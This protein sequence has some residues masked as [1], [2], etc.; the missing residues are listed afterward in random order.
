MDFVLGLPKTQRG[1]DSIYVVVDRFSKMAHFIACKKTNDATQI[2]NLFFSE[3][4]RLHGLPVS[5]VSD[6]DTKFVGHFW[7]TL[8]KKLGTKLSFSSAYHPQT[9]GQTEV[10]NR[11]L[12]NILRTLVHQNPKQWDL[13]LAQAEFAYNDTPNRSTGMSPFQIV[14]GMHPRGVY[15]LRDLG[16]QEARSASAEDFAEQMQKLHEEVKDKL[17]ESSRRYKQ[18]ADLKRREKEFQVG[19]LV[20]AY[21]RKERFPTRT[22][23]KLKLKKTGPCK[24]KRKISANAYEIEL[25]EGIE[26]SPIFNIADLYPFRE[27][28]TELQKEVT[29]DEIQTVDWEEQVPKSSQKEVEAILDRRISKKTRGKTYFQYL[30][31]WKEQPVEDSSWL[32]TIELQKYGVSP[33]GLKYK[34]FLPRESDA[35]ASALAS[36]VEDCPHVVANH[37]KFIDCYRE[38]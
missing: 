32:T 35:G 38:E 28:E 33:E 37:S 31:K 7:R 2:A 6:R 16:K 34:S 21:L 36:N 24:I 15:E 1:N 12:G 30:V 26:I 4:V 17:Q 9:D 27:A 5:I 23:N 8:W 25:L 20:M 14:F 22:Y 3:I 19:D 29:G 10:V 13:A 11:S 18:R